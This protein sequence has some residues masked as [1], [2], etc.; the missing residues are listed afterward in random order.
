MELNNHKETIKT[1]FI[2]LSFA[3]IIIL[4]VNTFLMIETQ[5]RILDNQEKKDIPIVYDV[6]DRVSKIEQILLSQINNSNGSLLP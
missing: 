3:G 6:N 1:F 2:F 4:S 5:Q